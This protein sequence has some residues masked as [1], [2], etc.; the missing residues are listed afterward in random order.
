MLVVDGVTSEVVDVSDVVIVNVLVGKTS[1]AL[2]DEEDVDVSDGWRTDDEL[3]VLDGFV[4]AS[5]TAVGFTSIVLDGAMTTDDDGLVSVT[6][7]GVGG[8]KVGVAVTWRR[9]LGFA[10]NLVFV[11]CQPTMSCPTDAVISPLPA[12]DSICCSVDI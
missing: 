11:T 8:C 6:V 4:E 5:G 3:E 2:D 1:V 12:E 9:R 7:L 10:W